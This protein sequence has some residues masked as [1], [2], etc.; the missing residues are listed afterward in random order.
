MANK[1]S[2]Q[3]CSTCKHYINGRCPVG[4]DVQEWWTGCICWEAKKEGEMTKETVF[5]FDDEGKLHTNSAPITLTNAKPDYNMTFSNENGLVGKLDFNG[6]KMIFTGDAEESAMIFM[7]WVATSFVDRLRAE[8]EICARRVDHIYK[9]G[10]RTWGD[11]I[12]EL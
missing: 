12:R 7:D 10:G 6:P 9:E 11:A 4:G 5:K 1:P 8:R 3:P 2:R